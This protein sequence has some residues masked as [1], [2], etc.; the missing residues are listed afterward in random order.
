MIVSKDGFRKTGLCDGPQSLR[1]EKYEELLKQANK[2]AEVVGK[3][4]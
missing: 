4:V 3:K 2:I 1:P